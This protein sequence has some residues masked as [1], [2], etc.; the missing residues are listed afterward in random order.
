MFIWNLVQ[1]GSVTLWTKPWWIIAIKFKAQVY[2]LNLIFQ[3][4][5]WE[6]LYRKKERMLILIICFLR[7]GFEEHFV[8]NVEA[9]VIFPF[10]DFA[11]WADAL[12]W[13]ARWRG[14]L[15]G[16]I[17]HRDTDISLW[18]C[19]LSEKSVELLK[20]IKVA[21][22]SMSPQKPSMV[23]CPGLWVRRIQGSLCMGTMH[24]EAFQPRLSCSAPWE[25][26]TRI[27]KIGSDRS[28]GF[29]IK[30]DQLGLYWIRM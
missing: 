23:L 22:S 12:S 19:C 16:H 3:W 2:F 24:N 1:C 6:L 21:L 14:Q 17:N 11:A 15:E 25:C 27:P 8:N 29:K 10:F 5:S 18:M 4:K 7:M 20:Q 30:G 13:P 9:A 28:V 26:G